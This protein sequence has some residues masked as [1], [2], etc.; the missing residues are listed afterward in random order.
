MN[1]KEMLGWVLILT[2]IWILTA[3]TVYLYG[4]PAI[5]TLLLVCAIVGVMYCG[6]RIVDRNEEDRDQ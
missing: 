6:A 5:I 1:N 3:L 2:P 4:I